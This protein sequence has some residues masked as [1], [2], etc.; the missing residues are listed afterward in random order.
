MQKLVCR[1]LNP[2]LIMNRIML[3]NLEYLYGLCESF[4]QTAQ[5]PVDQH[6]WSSVHNGSRIFGT[7]GTLVVWHLH[8]ESSSFLLL[9]AMPGAPSK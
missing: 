7:G 8:Q 4:R 2:S 3:V 1:I 5:P 9:V 6:L